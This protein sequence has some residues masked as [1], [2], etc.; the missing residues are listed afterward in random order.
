MIKCVGYAFK[1]G[2]F[3]DEKGKKLEY[4]NVMLYYVSDN[5]FD[6]FGLETGV[7]KVKRSDWPKLCVLP[8]EDL[9]DQ[10]LQFDYAPVNG[11]VVLRRIS[12]AD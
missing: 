3:E 1:S 5:N 9:R 4:D 11:K 6:V 2:S 7:V 12:L 10:Q 8:V